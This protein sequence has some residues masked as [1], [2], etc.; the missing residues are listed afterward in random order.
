MSDR[1]SDIVGHRCSL[2]VVQRLADYVD[3]ARARPASATATNAAVRCLLDLLG[4]AAAGMFEPGVAAVRRMAQA[5]MPGGCAPIWFTGE[6][7]SVLSAAWANSAAAAA[8]D[9]DDGH[10]LA[11]GHPGAAVIPTALAVA[12]ETGATIDVLL[13]AIVIGYEVG[14]SVGA[15]RLSYGNTGTWSAYA[16]VAAAAVLRGTSRDL[17]AH[18]FAIAGESAPNQL[19]SSAPAQTPLPEGSDVKEGIP[20]SVVTGLAALGL[21]EAGHTG[22]R[23]VLDSALHYRFAKN[24][25]PGSALHIG[26]VYFKL[27]A[28]CRHVHAPLDALLA[29][30]EA[31]CIDLRRIEMIEVE[32]Y[33]GALRISN[34]VR[35]ANLADIQ[36]SIPYC[37][38]LV[39]TLGQQSLLPLTAESLGN[40]QAAALAAKVRLKLD[41]DLEARFPAETLARVAIVCGGVRYVSAVT[42]PRGEASAP[43]SN[44]ALETKFIAATR[45][46]ATATQQQRLLNALRDV[47]SE[48]LCSL[49]ACLNELTLTCQ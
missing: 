40:E 30:I 10:R 3:T 41:F 49:D 14:I 9:L 4:A 6:R 2:T 39:A 38:G 5:A 48:D 19:F 24:F 1:T 16:V 31:H 25:E 13:N 32:T 44:D 35:P 37:L 11:R 15:A 33:S 29:L 46:V 20:W 18:A 26:N 8:L 17:L 28:C 21:A 12:S 42:A 22:P 34:S 43:L 27:Y 36:Y 23:N 45:K 47:R 7:G